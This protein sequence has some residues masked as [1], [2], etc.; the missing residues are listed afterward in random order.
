MRV[1]VIKPT[2]PTLEEISQHLEESYRSNL[3]SNG[4]PC[5]KKLE[6]NLS[7]WLHAD[8]VLM[9]NATVALKVVLEAMDL[10]GCDILVPSFTFAATACSIVDAGCRPILVDVDPETLALSL[11]DA[12]YKITPFTRALVVV[13][14]LGYV[15]DP[16]PYERFAEKY[17][18]SLIF[19]SAAALGA[20]Y[21]DGK[22][23]GCAGDA[24]VFSLHITKTFGIGEGGL[25]TTTNPVVASRCRKLINFGFDSTFTSEIVGT[26]AKMSEFHAAVGLAVLDQIDKK[27]SERK[28]VAD[29]YSKRLKSVRL[30]NSNTAHQ[31][32]PVLFPSKEKRDC[33]QS[34]LSEVGVG[35]RIYYKPLHLHPAFEAFSDSLYPVSQRIYDTILCLPM[36]EGL[37][38]SIIE[39]ICSIVNS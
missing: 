36:W 30:L 14:A 19:D 17:G 6:S 10:K 21:L 7:S 18:L 2:P 38:N 37:E 15:C 34:K 33:V 5:L 26:N 16:E 3:F 31:V 11:E 25:V 9:A 8:S 22:K 4:G 1:P 29:E 23:V 20:S 28:R 35:S 32:F 13:Q 24:E 27:L 12:E 39:E